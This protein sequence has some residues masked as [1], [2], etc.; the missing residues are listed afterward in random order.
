M[1]VL[2]RGFGI[3][4]LNSR[5]FN[6]EKNIKK[7]KA[8]AVT[9]FL[10]VASPVI[11]LDADGESQSNIKVALTDMSASAGM[12]PMGQMMMIGTGWGP[13]MRSME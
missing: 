11:T 2:R 8:L 3:R 13:G 6:R 12:G 9:T 5:N 10:V 4:W 1:W 7:I